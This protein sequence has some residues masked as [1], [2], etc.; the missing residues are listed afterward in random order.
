[1]AFRSKDLDLLSVGVEL[2]NLG[3]ASLEEVELDLDECT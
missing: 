3:E 2:I 1:M